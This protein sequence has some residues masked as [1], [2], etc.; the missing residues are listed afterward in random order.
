MPKLKKFPLSNFSHFIRSIFSQSLAHLRPSLFLSF[1]HQLPQNQKECW[2]FCVSCSINT[3]DVSTADV[4]I[5][6]GILL[7]QQVT[8]RIL[9]LSVK[10][11]D[12]LNDVFDTLYD[13]ILLDTFLRQAA[14]L[15]LVVI[16]RTNGNYIS[17]NLFVQSWSIKWINTPSRPPTFQELFGDVAW[18]C[19][20]SYNVPSLHKLS[21]IW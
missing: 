5:R 8:E 1:I 3:S 4:I 10:Y 7:M 15:Q 13:W 19:M 12:K 21:Y 6:S 9:S 17:I 16:R 11:L 18:C 20:S 2:L 14:I